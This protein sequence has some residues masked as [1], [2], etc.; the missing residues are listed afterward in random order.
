MLTTQLAMKYARALYEV[1]LE[2]NQ[3]KEFGQQLADATDVVYGQADLTDFI[4]HPRIKPEAKKEVVA[5]L[6]EGKLAKVV[7]NFF[8][9]LIDKR[10]ESLLKQ[11]L[12]AYTALANAAQNIVEAEVTVARKLSVEQES[13]LTKKLSE[14]T[15][16]TVVIK[17]KIDQSILGGVVVKIGDKLIDGSVVRRMQVLKA[18]LLTN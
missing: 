2:E 12:H 6:F 9:L 1:A 14:T 7:Y 8:M 13:Q 11:I 18:Q 4:N 15:G 5:K 17:T 16:K 10:R 3:L